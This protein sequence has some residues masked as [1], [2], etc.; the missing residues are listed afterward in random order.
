MDGN[1]TIDKITINEGI[2]LEL[3]QK[4]KR[5]EHRM[6]CDKEERDLIT[7]KVKRKEE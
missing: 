5:K 6:V 3:K 4:G 2:I 7:G 1:V